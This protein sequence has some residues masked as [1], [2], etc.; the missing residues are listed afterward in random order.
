MGCF[1]FFLEKRGIMGDG[2]VRKGVLEG[3]KEGK[4]LLGCK[5]NE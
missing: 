2:E 3:S 4:L 5:V 1:F